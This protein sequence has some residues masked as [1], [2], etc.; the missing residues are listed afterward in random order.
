MSLSKK[1]WSTQLSISAG[2]FEIFATTFPL[3]T[4]VVRAGM[5][6]AETAFGVGE[7]GLAAS[8]I[9]GA[10]ATAPVVPEAVVPPGASSTAAASSC[11]SASCSRANSA[12]RS[13]WYIVYDAKTSI[14]SANAR[15]VLRSKGGRPFGVRDAGRQQTRQSSRDGVVAARVEGVAAE[16][17][18]CAEPA[19]AEHAVPGDRLLGELRAAR[20]EAAALAE[21]R[22]DRASIEKEED[23]NGEQ[24]LGSLGALIAGTSVRDG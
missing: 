13:L 21:N 17:T 16:Q 1:S 6:R 22:S 5:T 14:E 10:G 15:A 19:P 3:R 8:E 4:V 23:P 24:R 2:P 11:L 9:D 18:P 12:R 20:V 7:K